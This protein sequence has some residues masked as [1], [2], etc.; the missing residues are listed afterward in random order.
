MRKQ[1]KSFAPVVLLAGLG[2]V[3]SGCGL[4]STTPSGGTTTTTTTTVPSGGGGFGGGGFGGGGF[5]GILDG[6]FGGFRN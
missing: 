1:F 2:L 4:L 3:A 6:L 5:G